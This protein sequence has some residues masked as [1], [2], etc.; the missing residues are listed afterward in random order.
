MRWKLPQKKGSDVSGL[1]RSVS[2]AAACIDFFL[3][4]GAALVPVSRSALL[5]CR[6]LLAQYADLPAD[7]ADATLVALGEEMDVLTV[8]TL[9][10]RGFSTYRT[11]KGRTFEVR[12]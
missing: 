8:Y 12:P 7:F 4:G 1:R 10:R 11:R 2:C 3:R 6:D 5:R 9:D